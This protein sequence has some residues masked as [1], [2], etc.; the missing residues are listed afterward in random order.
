ML[1]N[2][3]GV[4]SLRLTHYQLLEIKPASQITG[5][6]LNQKGKKL[7]GSAVQDGELDCR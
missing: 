1:M 6:F 4:I 3:T 2:I 5:W 7:L